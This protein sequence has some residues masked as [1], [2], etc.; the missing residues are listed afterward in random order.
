MICKKESFMRKFFF[1]SL[2]L[3]F[4]F[5]SP[6][7]AALVVKCEEKVAELLALIKAK[8]N[9][10]QGIANLKAWINKLE[11]DNC[12]LNQQIS[13]A[14]GNLNSWWDDNIS[15][16][17]CNVFYEAAQS[18]QIITASLLL[19]VGIDIEKATG[20]N[21]EPALSAA[22]GNGHLELVKLL[23]ANG[24]N[25]NAANAHGWT[26]LHRAAENG[27]LEVVKLL[28]ASKADSTVIGGCGW[29]VLHWAAGN[30]HAGVVEE[31]LKKNPSLKSDFDHY[32]C[33]PLDRAKERGRTSVVE[34]LGMG[35]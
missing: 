8:E 12:I 14:A 15:G 34:L 31:L 4:R 13:S 16:D 9:N 28:L 27:R 1:L 23:L 17:A 32:D 19:A 11:F 33:T 7:Q 30:G 10:D 21:G 26:V 6:S 29:N 25:V 22:A 18:G 3:S 35:S 5:V 2:C 20:N 24:A